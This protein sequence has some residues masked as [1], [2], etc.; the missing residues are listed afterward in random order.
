MAAVAEFCYDI[1]GGLFT[2]SHDPNAPIHV[3]GIPT[4]EER[5]FLTTELQIDEHTLQSALDP[6]E[7]ARLEFEPSHVAVILKRPESVTDES[8]A[9][10]RVTSVGAFLFETRLV[11]VQGDSAVLLGGRGPGG[12]CS[13][14]RGALLQLIYSSIMRFL[15]DVR[16]VQQLSNSIEERIGVSLG[17]RALSSMFDLQKGLVM[18][19]SAVQSNQVLLTKLRMYADRIGFSREER[20][21]LDDLIVEN[22]Q[23]LKLVELHERIL[24][25]MSDARVSIINNNLTVLMKKLTVISTIF[26]PLNLIASMGG[27]SEWTLITRNMPFWESYSIFSGIMVIIGLGTWIA[28][29]RIGIGE[30][31]RR[32]RQRHSARPSRMPAWLAGLLGH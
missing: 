12:R 5:E 30:R 2:P 31:P 26:L 11:I 4:A 1:E 23:C 20:E 8:G 25:E 28:I 27:M 15:Q 9:E 17:N 16:L 13:T 3:Y 10:F 19:Q 14:L 29:R 7:L 22:E 32:K 24:T 6:D 21:F 18:Y